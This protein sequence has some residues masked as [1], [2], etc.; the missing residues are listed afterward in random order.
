M[1]GESGTSQWLA[2]CAQPARKRCSNE[3]ST[4]LSGHRM[5]QHRSLHPLTLSECNPEYSQQQT[6]LWEQMWPD[7]PTR[8]CRPVLYDGG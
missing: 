5:C 8:G 4:C 1:G 7:M 2:L 3:R 6:W